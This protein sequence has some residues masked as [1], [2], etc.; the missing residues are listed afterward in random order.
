MT[1]P[2]KL[3][4][5]RIKIT[6]YIHAA[7]EAVVTVEAASESDAFDIVDDRYVQGEYDGVPEIE[8]HEDADGY[9]AYDYELEI[10]EEVDPNG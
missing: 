2:T 9:D 10:A 1:E 8:W 5:Y 3:S 4:P 6:R 7:E